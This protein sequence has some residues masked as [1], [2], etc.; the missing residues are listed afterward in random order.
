MILGGVYVCVCMCM[1][2]YVSYIGVVSVFSKYMVYNC[3]YYCD[4][5]S[6]VSEARMILGVYVCVCMCISYIGVVRYRCS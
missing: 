5:S 3:V 2:V 6:S 4:T 1:Y